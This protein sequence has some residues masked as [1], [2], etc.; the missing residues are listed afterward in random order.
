ME[1]LREKGTCR[2][3]ERPEISSLFVSWREGGEMGDFFAVLAPFGV[4]QSEGRLAGDWKCALGGW[5]TSFA[6]ASGEVGSGYLGCW[7]GVAL[8]GDRG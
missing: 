7:L 3:G 4:C 1:E 6:S 2:R 8:D 5:L